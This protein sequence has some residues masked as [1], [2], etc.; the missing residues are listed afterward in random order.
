M[1][2][3]SHPGGYIYLTRGLFDFVGADEDEDY[4]LQF[5][6]GHEIAHVDMQHAIRC[7]K[8]ADLKQS[9]LGTLPQFYLF[10]LPLGYFDDQ[11]YEADR[12][13]F[14]QMKRL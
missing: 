5:V 8:D 12:W 2:A 14:D 6:I 3:F 10:I 9:G 4:V 7:L 11:D 13:A 1:N